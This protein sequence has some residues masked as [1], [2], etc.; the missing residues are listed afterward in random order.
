MLEREG[1]TARLRVHAEPGWLTHPVRE[2]DIEH[3]DVDG[4]DV[5]AH[6]LLE[7]VH[8]EPSVLLRPNGSRGHIVAG[9]RVERPVSPRRPLVAGRSFRRDPLDDRDEL[10]ETGVALVAQE[11]VHLTAS[12]SVGRVHRG[13]RV[14][15]R[16][17]LLEKR[18]PAHH[19]VEAAL[20]ALVDPVGVVQLA[21]PSIDK[22][23]STPFVAKNSAHS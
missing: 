14:P 17:G 2:R 7:H 9:L 10:D 20:A 13:Q 18:E 23:T 12:V 22:P 16:P 19:P 5:P 8:E 6:P 4:P 15:F 21:G 3:L 11:A 1:L